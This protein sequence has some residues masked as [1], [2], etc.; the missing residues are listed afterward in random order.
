MRWLQA[1]WLILPRRHHQLH[2]TWPY[3]GDYCITTGW[4]NALLRQLRFWRGLE[5][6]YTRVLRLR[7]YTEATPWERVPGSP[8]FRERELMATTNGP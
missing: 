7:L 3:D 1:R 4:C 6:F 5:L 8:A 2:H